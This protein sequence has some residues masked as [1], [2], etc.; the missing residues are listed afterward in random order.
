MPL[1]VNGLGVSTTESKTAGTLLP[2]T[3]I[4]VG[5]VG[6]A[7]ALAHSTVSAPFAGTTGAVG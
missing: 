5:V 6:A 4:I 2:Q 3:S 1:Q 7:A